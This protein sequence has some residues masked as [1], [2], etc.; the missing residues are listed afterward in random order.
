MMVGAA[1]AILLSQKKDPEDSGSV[2]LN[3]VAPLNQCHQHS[4]VSK[5]LIM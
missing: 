5:L 4:S 2:G 1:A 3:V